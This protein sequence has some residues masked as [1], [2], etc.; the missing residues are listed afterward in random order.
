MELKL[1]WTILKFS[2]RFRSFH[3]AF[4]IIVGLSKLKASLNF[5]RKSAFYCFFTFFGRRNRFHLR[6]YRVEIQWKDSM[7]ERFFQFQLA[8]FGANFK[9]NFGTWENKRN[10]KGKFELDFFLWIFLINHFALT[11][12]FYAAKWSA[13]NENYRYAQ[14]LLSN[15]ILLSR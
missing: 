2:K 13:F 14:K 11:F 15:N 8:S 9:R 10:F 6:F 7:T 4:A 3:S 1:F 12:S 5:N